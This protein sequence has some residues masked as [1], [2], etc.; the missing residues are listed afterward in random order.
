MFNFVFVIY[1]IVFAC[2][3]SSAIPVSDFGGRA[4]VTLVLLLTLVAF[5]FVMASLIPK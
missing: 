4:S 2:V 3:T 5:K 1:V